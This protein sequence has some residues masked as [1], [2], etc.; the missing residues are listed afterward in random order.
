MIKPWSCE[1]AELLHQHATTL[2]NATKA[3]HLYIKIFIWMDKLI[4]NQQKGSTVAILFKLII[5]YLHLSAIDRGLLFCF[6]QIP[7]L[8]GQCGSRTDNWCELFFYCVLNLLLGNNALLCYSACSGLNL[9]AHQ[10]GTQ[11]LM[12]TG[13]MGMAFHQAWNPKIEFR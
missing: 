3:K 5:Y 2:R 12:T 6:S 7:L 1:A 8:L 4:Y 11:E 10:S 13:I 9:R